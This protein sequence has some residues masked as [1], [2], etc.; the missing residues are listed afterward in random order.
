MLRTE[1]K[2]MALGA[3]LLALAAGLLAALPMAAAKAAPRQLAAGTSIPVTLETTVSS[4]TSRPEDRVDARVSADVVSGGK[5][6][7]PAGSE[8]RG[9]VVSARRSGRVKGL[10]YLSVSFDELMA[11]G[12]TYRIATERIGVQAKPTHGRDAKII[13]GGAGAGALLGALFGGG[14]GAAKGALLG[15]G[16]GTGAVLATRGKE[17]TLASGSRWRVRLAEPLELQ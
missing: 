1:I 6:V 9:Q 3:G 5:V 14:G 4:A 16:T 7:I 2:S 10:A 15:A 17:V 12:R 13:G 8:L 11:N